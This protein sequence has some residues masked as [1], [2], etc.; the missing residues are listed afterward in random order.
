MA[1]DMSNLA[2]SQGMRLQD[3][4]DTNIR[5][6]ID[7]NEILRD[8]GITTGELSRAGVIAAPL[9]T[10]PLAESQT[11]QPVAKA[12]VAAQNAPLKHAPA[13]PH[14]PP[15]QTNRQQTTGASTTQMNEYLR[16]L[17]DDPENAPL[18]LAVARAATP[19][20][21]F[22]TAMVQYRYLIR[23]TM[24]LDEVVVDLR[25]IL[26]MESDSQK[27]REC[28]RLLG[29]AYARQGRVQEAVEAYRMTNLSGPPPAL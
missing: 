26:A 2:V 9:P 20:G 17:Q 1:F 8:V 12:A 4:P 22:E 11:N 13:A 16:T 28:S 24:L 15:I 14:Q 23:T 29:N 25:D 3:F 19:S 7:A 27:R 5:P 18:R 10:E 6:A 21:M